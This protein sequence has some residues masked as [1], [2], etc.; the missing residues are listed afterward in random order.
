MTSEFDICIICG[1]DKFKKIEDTSKIGLPVFQ[2]SLCNLIIAGSTH[3]ERQTVSSKLYANDYWDQQY[4][5][6]LPNENYTDNTSLGKKRD[7]DSQYSNVKKY[8][9]DITKCLEIG[10]G[11]GSTLFWLEQLGCDVIGIEPDNRNVM[12]IN[13]RLKHGKC[14]C[15]NGEEF[16]SN[17]SFDLIWINH[18]LEHSLRPD[19][20]LKN[21]SKYLNDDGLIMIEV[22]NCENIDIF[23]ASVFT[24]PDN[25]H[26]TLD[27]FKKLVNKLDL[28]LVSID[29]FRPA[30]KS[31]GLMNKLSH[32]I[33][34]SLFPFYP[35]IKTNSKNGIVI[36]LLIGKF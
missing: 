5:K 14:I 32:K 28:K 10:S 19:I 15:G 11:T 12:M 24:E 31:E 6:Y 18:V 9:D 13:K 25:Y 22:P 21:L 17:E 36:R 1:N 2:C 4:S 29:Y 30:K 26:F 7:F 27:V 35:R 33:N 16:T 8:L 3:T 20:I 23:H 34:K